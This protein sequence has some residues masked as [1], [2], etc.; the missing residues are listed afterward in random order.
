MLVIYLSTKP[1]G[2]TRGMLRMKNTCSPAT[3][4]SL[5]GRSFFWNWLVKNHSDLSSE[6]LSCPGLCVATTAHSPGKKNERNI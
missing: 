1:H 4:Y 3:I 2:C 6:H 5:D